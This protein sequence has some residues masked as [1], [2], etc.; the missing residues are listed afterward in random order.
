MQEIIEDIIPC[1]LKVEYVYC[2]IT[3]VRLEEQFSS[4]SDL[5][6]NVPNWDALERML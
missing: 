2:Y 5:E 6:A 1:H 3:W 4:W